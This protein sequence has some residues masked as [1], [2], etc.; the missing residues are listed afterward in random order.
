M[1]KSDRFW[2][3]LNF[4]QLGDRFLGSIDDRRPAPQNKNFLSHH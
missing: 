2:A 1:I 4:S 3:W